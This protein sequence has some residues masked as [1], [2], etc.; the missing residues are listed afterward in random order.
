MVGHPVYSLRRG[1]GHFPSTRVSG[2]TLRFLAAIGNRLRR[3]RGV[4]LR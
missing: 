3:R 2:G 1:A 4:D